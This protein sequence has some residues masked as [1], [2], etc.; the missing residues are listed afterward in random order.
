[1]HHFKL[2]FACSLEII[3]PVNLNL[4]NREEDITVVCVRYMWKII[5]IF[6]AALENI[7][8]H[9]KRELKSSGMV[10]NGKTFTL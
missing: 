6:N 3:L 2:F 5:K 8:D 1:M 9:F 7:Q 10:F 4:A